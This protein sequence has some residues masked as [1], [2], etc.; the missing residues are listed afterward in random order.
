MVKL[1]IKIPKWTGLLDRIPGLISYDFDLIFDFGP[2]RL[3]GL[4][5][6]GP[7]ISMQ[8]GWFTRA[9]QVFQSSSNKRTRKTY[10]SLRLCMLVVH[11]HQP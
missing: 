7:L 6:N 2:E 9:T 11:L 4:T 8:Y 5:K 10:Q 1:L 3:L